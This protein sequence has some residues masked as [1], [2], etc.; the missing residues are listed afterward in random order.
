MSA[1]EDAVCSADVRVVK[2][3][4]ASSRDAMVEIA[5]FAEEHDIKPV[6]ARDFRFDDVVKAFEAP[7]S[8][9]GVGKIMIK[10]SGEWLA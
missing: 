3:C 4:L 10:V 9:T 8:Q 2:G 5:R 7:R 1:C 6:V